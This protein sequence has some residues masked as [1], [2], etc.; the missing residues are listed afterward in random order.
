MGKTERSK[1]AGANESMSATSEF[2]KLGKGGLKVFDLGSARASHAGDRALAVANFPLSFQ[3]SDRLVGLLFLLP[4]P[5]SRSPSSMPLLCSR[6]SLSLV[7]SSCSPLPSRHA[8]SFPAKS[9]YPPHCLRPL[10]CSR[11]GFL[12]SCLIREPQA[13]FRLDRR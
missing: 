4:A 3:H 7:L 1:W 6:V 9:L 2:A 10:G 11:R 12:G 8:S 5:R 13:P